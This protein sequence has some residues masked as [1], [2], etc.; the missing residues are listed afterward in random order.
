MAEGAHLTESP[1]ESAGRR[2]RRWLQFAFVAAVAWFGGRELVAQWEG[3][4]ALRATLRTDWTGV[5]L[6][7][8]M[9]LASYAVLIA[10][11]RA[12]VHAW[13][14]RLGAGDAARIWLVSNLGRYLPGKVWQ[15]GAMGMMAQQV[16]VAP[17]AAV[18][19]ALV[20]SLVHLLAGF[21]VVALTGGELLAGYVPAGSPLPIVLATLAVG[22]L[23]APWL[24]PVLARLA[25]RITGRAIAAPALPP[26][27]IWL[28]VAG[29]TLAWVLQGL[30]FG[31]LARAL[32]GHATGDAAST[33]A[34]YTLS[35]QVGFIALFAP[36]G[37]GVREGALHVLLVSAALATSAEATLL[38]V[39]SRLW[40]TVL[41]I[42]PGAVLLLRTPA[43][44]RPAPSPR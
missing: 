21:A 10:T 27:A 28:A 43:A 42:L 36:G 8:A 38:V 33:I 9:V 1:R 4:R 20:V 32:V 2:W 16:G 26:R 3:V 37:I 34:V 24:L 39:A 14:A 35:Y 19:S 41:E 40:L 17:E 29:S 30:A 44:S 25:S 18:G 13:G 31:V 15:I 22:I 12:T 11:W 5:L 6:A 23:A 7:S